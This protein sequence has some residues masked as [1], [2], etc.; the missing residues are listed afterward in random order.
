MKSL[1]LLAT[2]G[3]AAGAGCGAGDPVQLSGNYSVGVTN[4]DNSCNFANWTV[5]AMTSAVSVNIT[6]QGENATADVTGGVGVVLDVAFGAHAFSGLV[7]GNMLE[8]KLM[9]TRVTQTG[10]CTYTYDG[11]I[12]G[13]SNGDLLTGR[14]EYRP[15]TNGHSDCASVDGCL[16][17][18]DFN[19]SRPPQ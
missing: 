8:L 19:G 13:T 16:T 7:T 3:S 5:G 2:V 17:Y 18:Q 15:A 1:V 11:D 14:I 4:R 12:L 6:Q 9:G 10:N